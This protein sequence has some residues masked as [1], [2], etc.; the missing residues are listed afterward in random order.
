MCYLFYIQVDI[1]DLSSLQ[2]DNVIELVFSGMAKTMMLWGAKYGRNGEV[3]LGWEY[4]SEDLG[5][6]TL[7]R[8][9]RK[10]GSSTY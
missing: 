10:Q 3:L 2:C 8:R 6:E 4:P 7:L 5:W 1:F 9:R